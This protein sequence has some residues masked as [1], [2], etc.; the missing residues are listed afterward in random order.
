MATINEEILTGKKFRVKNKI[1]NIWERVSYWTKA[2]D[3]EFDDGQTAE[4]KMA[5]ME[6]AVYYSEN[7]DINAKNNINAKN[8]F[9]FYN[10]KIVNSSN[11]SSMTP[12]IN[13]SD[14]DKNFEITNEQMFMINLSYDDSSTT[15]Y[16]S[17]NKIII[18]G[19]TIPIYGSTNGDMGSSG[20]QR[21]IYLYK[22]SSSSTTSK[23]FRTIMIDNK[24]DYARAFDMT[25][26]WYY[27][28][29]IPSPAP[30]YNYS[31]FPQFYSQYILSA[32]NQDINDSG[33]YVD[34]ADYVDIY[35]STDTQYLYTKNGSDYDRSSNKVPSYEGN[36]GLPKGRYMFLINVGKETL[37]G[38]H[39]DS[40]NYINYD[41]YR[42]TEVGG[43]AFFA[44][45]DY[46]DNFSKISGDYYN[47]SWQRFRQ[48][49]FAKTQDL[50]ITIA[51]TEPTFL[52]SGDWVGSM[53]K[54]G[55]IRI[56][57]TN[58]EY[59]ATILIY[60]MRDF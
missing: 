55:R 4:E 31:T 16:I 42:N 10:Y 44:W 32:H 8:H 45:F 35:C 28:D 33:R 17:F 2:S 9:S 5:K 7:D 36:L 56:K 25:P 13:A 39:R 58:W 52:T 19:R 3:V 49:Q 59:Y 43:Y 38:T 1:K 26:Y 6:Y 27:H 21:S 34:Y 57:M 47:W 46:N 11:S 23:N 51:V 40:D 15:N 41:T 12:T 20:T 24:S 29:T 50:P 30:T 60:R 48:I 53:T 22:S 18:A 37:L 14:L 54:Q